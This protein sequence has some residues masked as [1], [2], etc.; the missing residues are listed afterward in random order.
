MLNLET[1][2]VRIGLLA[3][4]TSKDTELTA[5][6]NTALAIAERYCN[7]FF[8]F[9]NQTETFVH[10]FGSAVQLH[11]IPVTSISEMSPE[12]AYHID[13]DAGLIHFDHTAADHSFVIKY[14][15]GYDV[16]SLPADLE[17]ALYS[18]FDGTYASMSGGGATVAAGAIESITI[19]DVGTV[20]YSTGAKAVATT[21]AFGPV[22]PETAAILDLYRIEE[23]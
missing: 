9:G 16:D 11:R 14:I 1:L 4:D 10:K 21:S 18:I 8:A 15:G 22:S 20:R 19:A 7:R 3:T 5:A 17:W 23:C 2:R 13:A 6:M 12:H